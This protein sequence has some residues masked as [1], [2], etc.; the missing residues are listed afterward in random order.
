MNRK[1]LQKVIDEL[2]KPQ[3]RLDYVKGIL[4]T[5]ID[6]L[7]EQPLL[8]AT[9][10]DTLNPPTHTTTPATN[11]SDDEASVL[12]GIAKARLESIKEISNQSKNV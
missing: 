9:Q 6:G 5:M 11:F 3:P 7:P 1:T 8:V 12:D 10:V 2:N 4:E